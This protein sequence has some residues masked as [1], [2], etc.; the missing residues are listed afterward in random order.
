MVS[1]SFELT[2]MEHGRKLE[3]KTLACDSVATGSLRR[4]P[5]KFNVQMRPR[6]NT[7]RL[8]RDPFSTRVD[9]HR[10]R[11]THESRL[12]R[13]N[14]RLFAV[15]QTQLGQNR[16][17]DPLAK[18]NRRNRVIRLD[19]YSSLVRLFRALF[20]PPRRWRHKKKDRSF[21][22]C[23]CCSIRRISLAGNRVML[24]RF[25]RLQ[26][27]NWIVFGN[28]GSAQLNTSLNSIAFSKEVAL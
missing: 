4:S 16:W 8:G 28:A 25:L 9:R 14:Q 7:K 18:R 2:E 26:Q 24:D 15:L 13:T 27:K 3:A 12:R 20:F 17:R 5:L 19:K 22:I 23:C 1:R 6:W 21:F 11:P 10:T